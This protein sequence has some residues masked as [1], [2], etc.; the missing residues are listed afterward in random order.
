MYL[1]VFES[2]SVRTRIS[3]IPTLPYLEQAQRG[4]LE[5]NLLT[6]IGLIRLGSVN[7]LFPAESSLAC[8][9]P[10][11]NLSHGVVQSAPV[12]RGG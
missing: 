7:S 8:A 3:L 12:C 11:L 4:H 2:L 6:G 9:P 10:N 1:F 5:A